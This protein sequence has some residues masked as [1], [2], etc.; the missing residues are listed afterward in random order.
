MDAEQMTDHEAQNIGAD[1]TFDQT[2]G[3][4][5]E[6]GGEGD[7]GS[8]PDAEQHNTS[9]DESMDDPGFLNP[10]RAPGSADAQSQT[11]LDPHDEPQNPD[12]VNP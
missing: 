6:L 10:L 12:E 8:P 7:G 5:D 4:A 3:L 2:N 9:M 1:G 11:S